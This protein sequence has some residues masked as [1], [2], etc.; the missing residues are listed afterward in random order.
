M[1]IYLC[2]LAAVYLKSSIGSKLSAC[3]AKDE[4]K[5]LKTQKRTLLKTHSVDESTIESSQDLLFSAPWK[6]SAI[7]GIWWCPLF[8]FL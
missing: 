1:V 8:L 6:S 5:E 7:G 3:I 4:R 2:Q